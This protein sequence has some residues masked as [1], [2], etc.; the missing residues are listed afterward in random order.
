MVMYK[1]IKYE[2]AMFEL[3]EYKV[4]DGIME[5]LLQLLL[6]TYYLIEY[7]EQIEEGLCD[8]EKSLLIYFSIALSLLSL[9]RCYLYSDMAAISERGLMSRCT[10]L[11][12]CLSDN[13]IGQ[14]YVCPSIVI[15][16]LCLL[17]VLGW[18]FGEISMKVCTLVAFAKVVSAR[19][20][21]ACIVMFIPMH[22]IRLY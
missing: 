6:Q 16:G 8:N 15:N 18:R 21:Y 4:L 13:S 14:K 17:I 1:S 19:G 11:K 5:N 20:S 7:E 3:R 12:N 22:L 2:R 10:S 9:S